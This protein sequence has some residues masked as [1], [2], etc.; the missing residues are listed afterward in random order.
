MEPFIVDQCY[1]KYTGNPFSVKYRM[2]ALE[3]YKMFMRKIVSLYTQVTKMRK[4][5]GFTGTLKSDGKIG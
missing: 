1:R 3:V 4:I 2:G 5:T